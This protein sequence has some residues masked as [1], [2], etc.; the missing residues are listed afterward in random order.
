MLAG[1][2]QQVRV[3]QHADHAQALVQLDEPHAAHVAG[4]VDDDI[5]VLH[6]GRSFI[7]QIEIGDDVV[8]LRMNL[9][10]LGGGLDVNAADFVSAF[11]EVADEMSADKT[12][13]AAHNN[14]IG[15]LKHNSLEQTI[16]GKSCGNEQRQD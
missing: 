5:I 15:C 16:P 4:Q 3:D 7:A 12:A 13:A 8:R 2:Q 6:R 1:A 11:K 10:P 14:T 9:V